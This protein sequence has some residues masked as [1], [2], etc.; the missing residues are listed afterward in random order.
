MVS[1]NVT[2]VLHANAL[3]GTASTR[4]DIERV[5]VSTDRVWKEPSHPAVVYFLANGDRV[6]IGVSTNISA[7]VITLSL[8]K[9]N[10]ALLLEGAYDLEDALHH[11]FESD[12]IGKTEWFVLSRRIQ[13][14][15]TR[16][17]EADAALRQ[18]RVSSDQKTEPAPPAVG[19]KPLEK[20]A[21][22]AQAKILE[23]LE[24]VSNPFQAVY[25]HKSQISARTGLYES[26][27]N[28]T[29]TRLIKAQEIHRQPKAGTREDVRGYYGLGPTPDDDA[30]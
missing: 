24:Y 29:L 4:L 28:N 15:I 8:R 9:E 26:T 11:H 19:D 30:A 14:Y 20:K 1:M 3:A 6:K 18:P 16:R 10:A 17:K 23:A 22:T 5:S 25:L 12:R 13:D 27:L 2:D 21:P 7:R